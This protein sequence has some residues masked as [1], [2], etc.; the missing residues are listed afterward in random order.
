MALYHVPNWDKKAQGSINFTVNF[1]LINVFTMYALYLVVYEFKHVV[2]STFQIMGASPYP[3]LLG[4]PP[5]PL[6]LLHLHWSLLPLHWSLPPPIPLPTRLIYMIVVPRPVV[7]DVA[8]TSLCA[9]QS[10]RQL[11]FLL[12]MYNKNLILKNMCTFKDCRRLCSYIML[13]LNTR[14]L[15]KIAKLGHGRCFLQ[16][17]TTE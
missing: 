11:Y 7:N 2:F 16:R 9:E 3:L 14:K 15:P 6:D 12:Y 1:T 8:A 17:K 10:C 4:P 5:L 13:Y